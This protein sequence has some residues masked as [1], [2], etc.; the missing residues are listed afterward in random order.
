MTASPLAL[1]KEKFGGRSGLV[2][3]LA[4]MVDDLHDEGA[5]K[6]RSRLMSLSNAKLLRLY[7]TEQTVR[8]RFGDRGKLVDHIVSAR[9]TAGL[10]ADDAFR[11]KLG[12]FSKG[13]LLDLARQ[14]HGEAPAK[15]TPEQKL[16]AK[17]GKKARARALAK[18]GK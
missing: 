17:R 8:E 11:T 9:K 10:T 1:V 6:V 16:A 18:I 4:G 2:D 14:N 12:T 7:R 13:K 5:D 15:Q 3:K